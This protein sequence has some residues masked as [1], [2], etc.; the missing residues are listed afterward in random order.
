[1]RIF[2][3]LHFSWFFFFFVK[4]RNSIELIVIKAMFLIRFLSV[5]FQERFRLNAKTMLDQ[6]SYYMRIKKKRRKTQTVVFFVELIFSPAMLDR[7]YQCF[8]QIFLNLKWWLNVI[9]SSFPDIMS[10]MIKIHPLNLC[11]KMQKCFLIR[12][13]N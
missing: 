11:R 7:K 2:R 10:L 3:W 6:S 12:M 13:I 1:M 4:D 5:N 8:I 9:L